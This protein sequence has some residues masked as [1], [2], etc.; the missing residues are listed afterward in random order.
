MK[1]QP[2][3]LIRGLGHSG[4]TLLDLVLSSH[5][6]VVG[7]GEGIRVLRK[8]GGSSKAPVLLRGPQRATRRCS[9]G[10]LLTECG[11]WGPTVEWLLENDDRP[12]REKFDVLRGRVAAC[13]PHSRI[14]VDSSQGDMANI[15]EIADG[16]DVHLIFLVRDVRSWSYSC[17]GKVGGHPLAHAL[18]WRK[19]NRLAEKRLRATGLPLHL[20]GY[21]ELALRPQAVLSRLCEAIGLVFDPAML[22]PGVHH[23]SHVLVGNRMAER[24]EAI[25]AVT[26]DG[27]WLAAPSSCQGAL[28]YPFFSVLNRRLVYSNDLLVRQPHR[29]PTA[30]LS[31]HSS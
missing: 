21:E 28:W 16:C 18:K 23:K 29:P 12:L 30:P 7:V 26:Y 22:A 9:C 17:V 5:P 4:T 10:R 8:G 6:E 25:R 14:I 27:S 31:S 11:V 19:G 24:P 1:R 2:L 3:V 20:I 15:S 13:H